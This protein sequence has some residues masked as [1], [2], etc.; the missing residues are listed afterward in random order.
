[1][2]DKKYGVFSQLAFDWFYLLSCSFD[3]PSTSTSHRGS[4]GIMGFL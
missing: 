3:F 1:M 2:V 4:A